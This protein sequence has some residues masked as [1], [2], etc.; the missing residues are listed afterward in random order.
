MRISDRNTR[1]TL[2]Y[3]TVVSD[4][5]GGEVT[6]WNDT[7]AVWAK[8]TAYR[9][10]ESI[11]AMALTGVATYNFRIQYRRDVR[12]SWRI[13]EGNRYYTIIGAPLEVERRTWLDLTAREAA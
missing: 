10:N 11:Q 2:Q 12:S 7:P 4:G 1:I 13:K 8:K 6:T 3:E 9:S 5:M